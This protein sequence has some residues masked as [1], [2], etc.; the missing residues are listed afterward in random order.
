VN[1]LATVDVIGAAVLGLATLRGFWI[2]GV[3]EA[4]SVAGLAAAVWVARAWR[5]PAAAWLL[6]HGPDMTEFTARTVAA[7][8]LGA[9]TLIAVTVVGRLAVRGVREAG[10]GFADRT[11]GALLGAFE[12]ALVMAALVFGLAALLGRDDPALAGTRSLA[13]YEWMEQAAGQAG[14]TAPPSDRAR[15]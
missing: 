3:R 14:P 9:V 12:G 1:E 8:V 7:L 2:G 5:V 15:E 10:L 11:L 6:A 13:A 4:F